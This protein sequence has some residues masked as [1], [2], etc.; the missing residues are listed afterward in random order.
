MDWSGFEPHLLSGQ[1]ARGA[2]AWEE[3]QDLRHHL[4]ETT[5]SL[6]QVSQELQSPV[7]QLERTIQ[8]VEEYSKKLKELDAQLDSLEEIVVDLG[9]ETPSVATLDDSSLLES[10]NGSRQQVVHQQLIHSVPLPQPVTHIPI[11]PKS[12]SKK[13]I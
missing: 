7:A 5:T 6:Q 4:S 9:H 10:N 2:D 3:L 8:L 13:Q 11:P 1:E 12:L